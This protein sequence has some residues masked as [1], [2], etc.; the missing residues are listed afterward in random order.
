MTSILSKERANTKKAVKRLEIFA[1]ILLSIAALGTSW[2]GYQAARWSG[3]QATNYSLANAKRVESNQASTAAGQQQGIDVQLFTQWLNAYA[4][5]N[6]KLEQ[7]YRN[8]FRPEFLPAFEVWLGSDPLDNVKAASSPFA[9][10]QYKLSANAQA[11]QAETEAVR[12]FQDGQAANQQ[13]DDY[14]LNTVT[15]SMVLFLVSIAGV[16]RSIAARRVLLGVAA[17]MCVA[18]I[19]HLFEFPIN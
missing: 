19:Y 15:F 3:V 9:L 11:L 7:F 10:P 8:R 2:S 5:N 18:G 17:L 12:I 13:S 16:T 14:I 6:A 1:A 4:T